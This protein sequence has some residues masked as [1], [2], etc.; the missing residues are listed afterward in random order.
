MKVAIYSPYLDTFGGGEK[1]MMTIAW[2]LSKAG[3]DVDMLLD[4]NLENLGAKYL[5]N[6][7]SQRFDINLEKVGFIN[8]PVG[9]GS[10]FF[11]RAFFL[12]RYDLFFYLTDGSI[13]YSSAKKNILHIQSPIVGQPSEN[14]LGKIKL[15]SWDLIIYNSNFTKGYSEK[16]WPMRS[17]VIYPP[18]DVDKIKSLKKK[19]YIL[20]VGRFFGY[21]RDKKQEVLIKVFKKLY[22]GGLI[23][24]WSLHLV[25]S[26]S[27]GDLAYLNELR[28]LAKGFPVK[29]YPN[30]NYKMVLKLYGESSIYW[31]ASGFDEDDP[32]RM[33]HFGISIVEAMA[34]GVVPVVVGKAGP[35]EII[36]DRK[37]GFLW[38]TQDDLEQL[39]LE[40]I[41]DE[42]L[43]EQISRNAIKKAQDFDLDKFESKILDLERLLNDEKTKS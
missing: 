3:F 2:V 28:N 6:E 20:S 19:K 7:L 13:F 30:L 12:K 38:Q 35:A 24:D 8:G 40:L 29:F 22:K 36:Q 16:N 21:L 9:K 34:A 39:N 27:S 26:A 15:K 31:H 25:G 23:N 10:S 4:K 43:R 11:P 17:I 5:K 14:F 32:I 33:E 18:I 1:Y 37:T 42:K 41:R